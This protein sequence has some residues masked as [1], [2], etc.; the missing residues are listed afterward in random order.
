MPNNGQPN[1]KAGWAFVHGPGL[2]GQPARVEQR[3]PFGDEGAQT[4]NNAE[5]RAVIG[6]LRFR[7]WPGEGFRTVNGWK[8]SSGKNGKTNVKNR[9][10]WEMLLGEVERREEQGLKIQFWRIPREWNGVADAAAKKASA[11]DE[12]P[13]QWEEMMGLCI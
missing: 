8:T 3:G 12:A 1:P 11:E 10:L 6:A 9:D 4:S 13:G 7:H 5:L 2:Q